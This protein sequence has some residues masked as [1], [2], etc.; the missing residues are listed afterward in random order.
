M[1]RA[2]PHFKKAAVDEGLK[3]FTYLYL[4]VISKQRGQLGQASVHMKASASAN[5]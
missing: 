3:G 4:G 5:P 1:D 2:E